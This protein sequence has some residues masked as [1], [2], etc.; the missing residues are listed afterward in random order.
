MVAYERGEKIGVS[1][2]PF[3]SWQ[4][5]PVRSSFLICGCWWLPVHAHVTP[6]AQPL[7]CTE[8]CLP[9]KLLI[10]MISSALLPEDQ[11]AKLERW[12][13]GISRQAYKP[14]ESLLMQVECTLL[15]HRPSLRLL[16]PSWNLNSTLGIGWVHMHLW[17]FFAFFF[18]VG[19]DISLFLPPFSGLEAK[20]GSRE[21]VALSYFW[22]SIYYYQHTLALALCQAMLC[23]FQNTST[24]RIW[25]YKV[26]WQ[27]QV[28]SKSD[29]KFICTPANIP[30]NPFQMKLFFCGKR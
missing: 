27:I 10:G 24:A 8:L 25:T 6:L 14:L 13:G 16:P 15:K 17:G 26:T 11:I 28:L 30:E 23:V 18:G 4:M 2:C 5:M 9:F 19:G 21:I 3:I 7:S 22:S 1:V 29:W 12:L 20:V